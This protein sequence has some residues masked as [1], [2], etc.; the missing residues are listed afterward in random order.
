[1]KEDVLE[2]IVDDY[3]MS[4]G[5]LTSHDLR[6]KPNP[7]EDGFDPQRDSVSPESTWSLTTRLAAAGTA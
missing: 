3:P 5:Y 4:E 1:M 6:F 7:Q 2:Q